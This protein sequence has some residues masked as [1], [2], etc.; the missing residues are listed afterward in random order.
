[1]K[2]LAR[3]IAFLL[4]VIGGGISGVL[5]GQ[6][7][8]MTPGKTLFYCTA[9]G[10]LSWF[11]IFSRVIIPKPFAASAYAFTI[12]AAAGPLIAAYHYTP[13]GS[14]IFQTVFVMTVIGYIG[15]ILYA[16]SGRN[17][18]AGATMPR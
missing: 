9:L 2:L 12:V 8:D 17:A 11:Q 1:M 10:L 18:E 16:L 14:P 3:Q 5:L 4:V 6:I 15:G 13:E 7:D